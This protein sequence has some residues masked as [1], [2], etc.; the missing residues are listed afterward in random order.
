MK[1]SF[2]NYFIIMNVNKGRVISEKYT[3]W[4][5]WPIGVGLKPRRVQVDWTCSEG[6]AAQ[7]GV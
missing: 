2:S 4:K 1:T 6:C 5:L 3:R 7:D